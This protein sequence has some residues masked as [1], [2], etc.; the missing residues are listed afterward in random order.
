MEE[1]NGAITLEQARSRIRNQLGNGGS[2]T[3]KPAAKRVA[4]KPGQGVEMPAS[5]AEAWEPYVLDATGIV[6]ILSDIHVPYHS[7]MALQ[8]AVGHLKTV[9]IDALVLNGDT[10]DFYTISRWVKNPKKRDFRGEIEGHPDRVQ[11]WKP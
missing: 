9:G 7:E 11:V 3:V 4:R 1:A 6:G 2:K 10:C 8:A 5:K